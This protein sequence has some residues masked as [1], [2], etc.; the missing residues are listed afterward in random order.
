MKTKIE[1]IDIIAKSY[2]IGTRAVVGGKNSVC[3]YLTGSGL[4][5]GVGMFLTEDA[6]KVAEGCKG[7]VGSLQIHLQ[8]RGFRNL[9]SAFIE[10][11]RGHGLNFWG[12]MQN[13]HDYGSNWNSEGLSIEG[14]EEA[15][16]LRRKYA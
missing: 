15:D 8:A 2:T 3:N 5:C 16:L 11:V 1:I 4:K 14:K 13:L 9:D 10:E 6:L 12:E 7:N